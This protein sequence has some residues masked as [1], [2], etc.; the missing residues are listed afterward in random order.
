MSWEA[1]A[2]NTHVTYKAEL[3]ERSLEDKYGDW[4]KWREG[5]L[6]GALADAKIMSVASLLGDPAPPPSSTLGQ[7]Q[8]GM[9]WPW[10]RRATRQ[11][12]SRW[13]RSSARRSE[14]ARLRR[15][16]RCACSR[17]MS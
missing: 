4:L 8:V 7:A 1:N 14:K 3:V 10:P 17:P 11:T 2:Y 16:F 5:P 13:F 9:R 12:R 6:F 15:P